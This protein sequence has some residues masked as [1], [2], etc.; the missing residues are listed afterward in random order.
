MVVGAGRLKGS[1]HHHHAVYVWPAV[2]C[3]PGLAAQPSCDAD[4][5]GTL[6]GQLLTI[7]SG[8]SLRSR[9]RAR[10]EP[11]GRLPLL[12]GRRGE[13]TVAVALV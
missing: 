10:P 7:G 1:N 5:S 3:A 8:C 6:P 2:L 4:G 12:C 9:V 13:G 11:G